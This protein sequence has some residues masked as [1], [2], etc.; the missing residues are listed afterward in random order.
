LAF[1]GPAAIIQRF[2]P[3]I[4]HG[5]LCFAF[6]AIRFDFISHAASSLFYVV[7]F[8]PTYVP[9]RRTL[10]LADEELLKN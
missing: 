1:R 8:L 6:H 7:F 2:D 10:V 9:R 3:G 4:L 5:A